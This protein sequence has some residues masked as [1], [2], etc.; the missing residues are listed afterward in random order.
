MMRFAGVGI[1]DMFVILQC[2]NNLAASGR[3]AGLSV[4]KRVG[5]ALQGI[6][7][8]IFY[9]NVSSFKRSRWLG[10]KALKVSH[11]TIVLKL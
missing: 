1:D 10:Q 6:S 8:D 5:M 7:K 2:W 3:H 9:H 11:T 4:E